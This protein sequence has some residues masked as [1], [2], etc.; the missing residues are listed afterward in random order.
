M[1]ARA[2]SDG[3]ASAAAADGEASACT[4]APRRCPAPVGSPS[5]APLSQTT[6]LSPA[7]APRGGGL[8]QWPRNPS[9]T[10]S[11]GRR[12]ERVARTGRG[13]EA[14]LR[15]PVYASGARSNQLS[16]WCTPRVVG[17]HRAT[18]ETLVA[19]DSHRGGS[20]IAQQQQHVSA[21]KFVLGDSA[22]SLDAVARH[23]FSV[24][25]IGRRPPHQPEGGHRDVQEGVAGR[26]EPGRRQLAMAAI[27]LPRARF[28]A[29]TSL[30]VCSC[31][32]LLLLLP[33][34][35]ASGFFEL[36]VLG[37]DNPGGLLLDGGCC[38]SR[39]P[40]RCNTYFRLCL[41]EYQAQ[42]DLSG[43]CTFGNLTSPL[44]GGSSFSLQTHPDQQLLLRLPFHFRWTAGQRQ[45][46]RSGNS[47]GMATA[48]TQR[49]LSTAAIAAV[50]AS[51]PG[52]PASLPWHA[53]GSSHG[54]V[55]E[56]VEARESSK[57]VCEPVPSRSGS[58]QGEL[59]K[60]GL[61][62]NAPNRAVCVALSY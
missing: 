41:K 52:R 29:A 47:Q 37:I 60:E 6:A 16:G 15:Q 53:P 62:E 36:Q 50:A 61:E 30:L 17:E 59:W 23:G 11:H 42:V 33:A 12:R 58:I 2:L 48:T 51:G 55:D 24:A 39:C 46:A 19:L 7:T 31:A 49:E 38:G 3:V 40:G 28:C 13:G 57:P 10:A 22:R 1:S 45:D 44:I 14:A 32:L 20:S 18:A 43:A 4:C 8:F 25:R 5:T 27:A 56:E 35:R 9:S 34:A 26:P 54:G 21:A